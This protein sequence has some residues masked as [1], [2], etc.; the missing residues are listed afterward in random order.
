MDSQRTIGKTNPDSSSCG[1]L[2]MLKFMEYWT[3]DALSQHITQTDLCIVMDSNEHKIDNK[4]P[5]EIEQQIK[6]DQTYDELPQDYTMT[7]ND[8][9]AQIIIESSLA[10]DILVKIDDI[11]VNQDQLSCLLDPVTHL[12]D[13]VISAYIC[14]LKEQA[15]LQ[16]RNG[17]KVL[18]PINIKNTHWYLAVLHPIK[19]EIQVLD[20]LC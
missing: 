1:G 2:F 18:L 3:G 8:F 20:S 5:E 14:C 17:V 19:C 11:F 7:D 9:C 4:H 13:D 6:S 10:I 15:H 12:N 16:V